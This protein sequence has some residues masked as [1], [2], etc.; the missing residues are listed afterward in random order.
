MSRWIA[1]KTEDGKRWGVYTRTG[2]CVAIT[3]SQKRANLIAAAPALLKEIKDLRVDMSYANGGAFG[4]DG[5]GDITISI[6]DMR[7]L[8]R[9]IASANGQ[10]KGK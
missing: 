4:D 2:G 9:I 5:M 3:D 1:K 7:R 8:D 10:L 6:Y